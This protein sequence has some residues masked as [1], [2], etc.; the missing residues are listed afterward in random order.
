M[1]KVAIVGAGMS[2]LICAFELERLG[3]QPTI[4]E[5]SDGVGGRVKTQSIASA[6]GFSYRSD[7]GFQVLLT[8]YPEVRR[9]LHLS[10]LHLNRFDAAASVHISPNKTHAIG[11]PTRSF[12]WIAP[13]LTAPFANWGDLWKLYRLKRWVQ[14]Q[15]ETQIFNLPPQS[16]IDFLKDWGFSESIIQHFFT[17]FYRGIFLEPALSTSARLFLFVFKMFSEG[18]AAI[19]ASGMGEIPQQIYKKL[20]RTAFV[21]NEAIGPN[22]LPDGYDAWVWPKNPDPTNEP[23]HWNGSYNYVFEIAGTEVGSTPP[24]NHLFLVPAHLNMKVNN[25]HFERVNQD[26][27]EHLLVNATCLVPASV[28][29]IE[30]ELTVLIGRSGLVPVVHHFI[31]RALPNNTPMA[32][33]ID[34]SF[35]RGE[36]GQYFVGDG[37]FYPSLNAAM[38]SGRLAAALIHSDLNEAVSS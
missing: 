27:V 36:K 3:Y 23:E 35:I 31:P 7:E 20:H 22:E 10:E 13:S 26:G 25:Y 2:G 38:K 32:A 15:S 29:E 9:Y 18:D 11:D 6:S 1:N 24:I 4:F 33:E 8:A 12:R 30:A 34:P 17:P 5:A 28:Q 21:F 16:T 19:P 14:R 37:L